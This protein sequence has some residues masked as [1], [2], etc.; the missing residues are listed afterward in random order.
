MGLER[1]HRRRSISGNAMKYYKYTDR[2]YCCI[3]VADEKGYKARDVGSDT[4][5]TYGYPLYINIPERFTELT[6]EEFFLECI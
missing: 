1:N 6:E 2:D 4:W 3:I 5:Y